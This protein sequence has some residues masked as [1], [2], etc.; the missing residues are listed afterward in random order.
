M[1]CDLWGCNDLALERAS[2]TCRG[3][4]C[5]EPATP[6]CPTPTGAPQTRAVRALQSARSSLTA[7]K[8]PHIKAVETP[9]E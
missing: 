7:H 4:I 1:G 3:A 5:P 9:A 6:R 2:L 8:G